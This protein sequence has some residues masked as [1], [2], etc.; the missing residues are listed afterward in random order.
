MGGFGKPLADPWFFLKLHPS[1][2]YLFRSKNDQQETSS[3][4]K[5][6]GGFGKPLD[7]PWF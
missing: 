6:T 1:L 2:K 5:N 3:Y 7:D 4:H